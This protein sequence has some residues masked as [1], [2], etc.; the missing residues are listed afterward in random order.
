M[1][2]FRR[3]S[4]AGPLGRVVV[5]AAVVGG[6]AAVAWVVGPR[7]PER[8]GAIAAAAAVCLVGAAGAAAATALP[9]TTAAG[10]AA[11]PL[12]GLGLRLGPALVALAWL[13]AGESP[14]REAGAASLLA[15]F[16][17]AALAADVG[18]IIIWGRD[19]GRRPR[20]SRPN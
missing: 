17:L 20:D 3:R 18:R 14:L 15:I 7:S 6:A 13:Q 19:S 8:A 1:T 11:Y 2:A 12:V 16:Y 5:A 9:A 10:R 4:P